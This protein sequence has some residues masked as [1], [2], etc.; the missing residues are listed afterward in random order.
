MGER[1]I[2]DQEKETDIKIWDPLR[3]ELYFIFVSLWFTIDN[4]VLFLILDFQNARI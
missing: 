3:L 4:A 2:I 1:N